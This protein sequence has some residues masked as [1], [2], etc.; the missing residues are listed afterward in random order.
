MDI[1]SLF[2]LCGG[3]AFFLFGMRTMSASLEKIAGGRLE[4]TLKR[5]TANPLRSLLLGAG[6]TIAI[7]SSSALTVMLVGFVNS[8][9]MAL[10]QTV[11]VIMGANI[12]T[13]LTAWI[14]SL[15]GIDAQG[16]FALR[17]LR[18]ESFAPVLALTGV[19]MIMISR[20]PA[21]R[22]AGTALVGFAVLMYGMQLMGD[23]VSPL[24][25][26]PAFSRLLTAFENPLLGVLVGAAFTGVIQS[27]AASVGILQ[28]LAATGTITYGMAI[29]IV[30]GQNIGTCVTALLSSIGVSRNARRVAVI[31][32]SFNVIGTAVCLLLLGLGE[33]LFHPAAVQE[34]VT[35]LGVAVVHSGFN[36]FTAVVLLPFT[37]Q[38]EQLACLII[39]DRPSE[40]GGVLLDDRLLLS[41]GFAVR[42]CR[43]NVAVMADLARES[44]LTAMD[45]VLSCSREKGERV[46]ACEDELDRLEDQLGAFLTKL[47]ARE[48]SPEE[49]GQVSRLLHALN[50]LERMGDHALNIAEGAEQIA[51]RGLRFSDAARQELTTLSAAL[52]EILSIT[53]DAFARE[54]VVLARKV[55]PL[56]EVIDDLTGEI[57]DRHLRRLRTGEC[58]IDLGVALSELLSNFER[59]SDHCSNL[60][61]GLFQTGPEASGPHSYLQNIKA[62]STE[63]QAA[64]EA[65][66]RK[67]RLS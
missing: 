65:Y 62:D 1:F 66:R 37:R 43:E 41:P 40:E 60:A 6:I 58:A 9:I 45:M 21:R 18:P 36:I 28:V 13:T 11:G 63:F 4:L 10:G 32:I 57:R 42:Q 14:L 53:M 35:P 49:S 22:A 55:E 31:H 38:L 30:M 12:G 19:L 46:R 51:V 47:S 64:Y 56:E 2:T 15:T 44:A 52:S 3:L 50:D 8:G 26:M 61:A 27:S 39:P 33:A 29:P 59:V 23:A 5:M 17:L 67:Y 7:Q 34:T 16:N 20:R 24:A 54:D 25:D 48:I